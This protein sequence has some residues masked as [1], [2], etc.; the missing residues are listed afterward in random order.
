MTL[1]QGDVYWA[2]TESKRRPV[3]VVTR[4]QAIPVLRYIV[5]A[6]VTRTIRGIGTEIALGPDDGMRE[7]CVAAFDDLRPVPKSFLTERI[8]SLGP[9]RSEICRALGALA[10]C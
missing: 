2:E 3:L 10:D 4:S 1:H 6:P 9:R 7:D 8:G 5:V